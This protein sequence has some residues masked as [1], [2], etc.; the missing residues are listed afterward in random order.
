MPVRCGGRQQGRPP[1]L[2]C[3]QN[4]ALERSPPHRHPLAACPLPSLHRFRNLEYLE[5]QQAKLAAAAEAEAEEAQRWAGL[6]QSARCCSGV[7]L[8]RSALTCSAA[9]GPSMIPA[10]I[11]PRAAH[12]SPSP[13]RR[14]QLRRIRRAAAAEEVRLLGGEGPAGAADHAARAQLGSDDS[15][16]SE[17][18]QE[19]AAGGLGGA[20]L[21]GWGLAALPRLPAGAAG[22]AGGAPLDLGLLPE[23]EAGE[24][25][26]GGAAS[27]ASPA[28][29]RSRLSMASDAQAEGR[30]VSFGTA[31]TIPAHRPDGAGG[32]L[33]PRP[34]SA[35]R[36]TGSGNALLRKAAAAGQGSADVL[37]V[38]APAAAASLAR[39]SLLDPASDSDF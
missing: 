29:G 6:G 23:D 14:R 3:R 9:A 7:A 33:G 32:G 30:A 26:D 2:L 1:A 31:T 5:G 17:G 24:G 18:L 4:R 21:G 19:G 22:A 36:T 39:R 38:E 34:P 15:E 11:P 12:A 10:G 27:P 20:P 16:G 37:A 25:L 8:A 13:A 28:T 35:R